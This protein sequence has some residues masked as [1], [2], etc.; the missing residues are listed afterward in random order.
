VIAIQGAGFVV[1]GA[2]VLLYLPGFTSTQPVA[3]PSAEATV[4]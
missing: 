3:Q 4:A 1:G 2:L